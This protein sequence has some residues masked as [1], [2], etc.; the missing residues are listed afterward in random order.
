M[1]YVPTGGM[2]PEPPQAFNDFLCFGPITR[3]ATDLSLMFSAMSGGPSESLKLDKPVDLSNVKFYYMLND[4]GSPIS[5][6]VDGRITDVI[7]KVAKFFENDHKARVQQVNFSRFMMGSGFFGA[8]MNYTNTPKMRELVTCGHGEINPFIEVVK[9][10]FGSSHHTLPIIL[11]C[12][13]EYLPSSINRQ[14]EAN[15]RS[16]AAMK[17][18]RS[19]LHKFL[20]ED[21]VL[22]FP[23]WPTLAPKHNQ[24]L[25]R[26]F[27]LNYTTIINTMS[28]PST[29]A[30]LGLDPYSKLPIG[31]QVI[32]GPGQDRLSI[33]VAV[34]LERK[35][36]GWVPPS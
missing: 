36:G 21:S 5:T 23:T 34:E 35:F 2:F 16:I 4:G 28:V 6:L 14:S 13:M 10:M 20:G 27:D 11:L 15:R 32:A 24:T 8:T 3:Y 26:P 30:T 22:L 7:I 29:H 9:F 19:K 33:A 18:L 1:P 12:F 31:L 17:S 25:F